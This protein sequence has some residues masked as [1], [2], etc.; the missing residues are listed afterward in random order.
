MSPE[1]LVLMLASRDP[2]GDVVDFPINNQLVLD[3]AGKPVQRVRL[4]ILK[5]R[6]KVQCKAEAGR[7]IREQFRADNGRQPTSDDLAAFDVRQQ[8][9]DILACEILVRACRTEKRINSDGVAIY[10]AIFESAAWM[11]DNLTSDELGILFQK[12]VMTEVT[13]GAR[14][15]VLDDDPLT[16]KLWVDRC[17]KGLWALGPLAALGS[18]DL[19]ELVLG[20][21]KHM[22]KLE[23]YGFP[24]LDHRYL[25]LLSSSSADLKISQLDISSSGEQPENSTPTIDPEVARELAQSTRETL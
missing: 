1:E 21:A 25:S 3:R 22:A 7:I 23:S 9:D 12:Y 18:A 15:Q 16:L 8:Y 4:C 2:A 14:E 5:A 20:L 11:L 6:Q 17:K 24:I 19:A 10:G 13:C